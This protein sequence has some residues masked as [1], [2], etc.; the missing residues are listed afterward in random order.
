[1]PTP[2]APSIQHT[3]RE[4]IYAHTACMPHA[5]V[6]THTR[7][8][9][10]NTLHMHTTPMHEPTPHSPKIQPTNEHTHHTQTHT[11][12]T[13]SHTHT[14]HIAIWDPQYQRWCH[15]FPLST[16]AYKSQR[17]LIFTQSNRAFG[18][19]IIKLLAFIFIPSHVPPASNHPCRS[20]FH[21]SEL[22][23]YRQW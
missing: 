16:G 7:I 6:C 14:L 10:H 17:E 13:P 20:R 2:P 1:M 4:H 15:T 9:M 18:P 21:G 19:A 11:T 23:A 12:C 22:S 3:P 8:F 5:H